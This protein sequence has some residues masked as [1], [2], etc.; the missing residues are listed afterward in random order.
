ML[1]VERLKADHSI[2]YL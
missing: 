1:Q 2:W